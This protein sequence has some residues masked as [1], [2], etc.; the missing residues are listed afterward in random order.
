MYFLPPTTT[1]I[2]GKY[3]H[4]Q[5]T[6]QNDGNDETV[7]SHSLTEDDGDKVLGLDARCSDSTTNNAHPSGVDA[8]VGR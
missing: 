7:D 5:D 2:L 8:P 3:T 6:G 4:L 1:L